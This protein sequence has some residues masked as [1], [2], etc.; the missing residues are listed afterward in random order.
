MLSRILF[1]VFSILTAGHVLFLNEPQSSVLK[2]ADRLLKVVSWIS[3]G[4]AIMAL[5]YERQESKATQK[6]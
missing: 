5:R 1:L 2:W 6:R 4:A 3:F